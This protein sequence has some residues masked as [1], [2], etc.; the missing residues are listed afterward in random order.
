MAT[1]DRHVRCRIATAG[2]HALTVH[3]SCRRPNVRAGPLVHAISPSQ[4]APRP[5]LHPPLD[6]PLQHLHDQHLHDLPFCPPPPLALPFW[7]DSPPSAP[8]PTTPPHAP[9]APF[10]FRM[11]LHLL[12]LCMLLC[13]TCAA[14]ATGILT[15][16]ATTGAWAGEMPSRSRD[17]VHSKLPACPV[18]SIHTSE[19]A[20]DQIDRL[21]CAAVT[22]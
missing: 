13:C 17:G 1:S 12:C 14:H 18:Y 16:G 19:Y 8:T 22:D 21:S 9:L 2:S 15:R 20:Y 11:L 5:I 4:S 3:V 10:P 6:R 7:M